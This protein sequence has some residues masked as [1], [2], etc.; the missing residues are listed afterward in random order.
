MPL[1][2]TFGLLFLGV[3][4]GVGLT[5]GTYYGV[6]EY[7]PELASRYL[8]TILTDNAD[9]GTRGAADAKGTV[10]PVLDSGMVKGIVQDVLASE[11]GKAVLWDL[12]QSQSKE[13]FEAFFQEAMKSAEFRKALGDALGQF[14]ETAEGK[15]LLRKIAREALTP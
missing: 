12:V 13:T 15:E 10:L 8:S 14:L 5:V 3:V 1:S 2:R 11:Q 7:A 4:L 6:K 9:E